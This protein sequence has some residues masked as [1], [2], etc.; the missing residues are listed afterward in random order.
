LGTAVPAHAISQTRAASL[1]KAFGDYTAR[2]AKLLDVLYQRSRV[3]TRG[4]VL[5]EPGS[6]GVQQAF[7][8]A[9]G[10]ANDRGPTT[11]ERLER[12]AEDAPPLALAASDRALDAA[13]TRPGDITHLVTVSCTGFAAPGVDVRLIKDLGLPQTVERTH[14][15]FMGCHGALN[16]LRVAT[17]F[18]LDPRARVLVCAVELCS[19]HVRYGWHEDGLVANALFA[20]GAAACV[21]SSGPE[22]GFWVRATGSCLVPDSEDAMGWRIGD[23]GFEM[24]LDSSVPG[25]IAR[26]LRPWLA[27]WLERCG[28]TIDG[29]GSWAIHPGGPRIIRSVV[30]GLGL[31]EAAAE[32]SRAVLAEHGNMSSPTVLFILKRLQQLRAPGPV[33]ALAFGPGLTA[34][35][36]LLDDH[37]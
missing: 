1:A 25:L 16:G 3:H 6:D 9:S 23:H 27:A 31:P 26:H 20:D 34:E 33:V 8:P 2:Q 15:G 37:P 30:D 36:A 14:V 19:L 32:V 24:R 18:A 13:K 7:F 35:A 21:V 5:L 11:R 10:H 12:Y 22:P 29:V 17:A 4:S 28:L